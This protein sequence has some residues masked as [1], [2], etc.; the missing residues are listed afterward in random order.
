[1]F[2]RKTSIVCLGILACL[3]LIGCAGG[4]GGGAS[5]SGVTDGPAITS[6]VS[7][8]M[9]SLQSG[10]GKS[11]Q[12]Y[13]SAKMMLQVSEGSSVGN[14]T[15]WDFGTDLSNP[16]DDASFTFT[17]P[18]G[19]II[20]PSPD[21]AEVTAEYFAA[22]GTIMTAFFVLVK[23]DGAWYIDAISFTSRGTST[24]N[25]AS[26][27]PLA[28]G[29][30]REY[31]VTDLKTNEVTYE[32]TVIDSDP[33]VIDGKNFYRFSETPSTSGTT[34]TPITAR[35]TSQVDPLDGA[36]GSEYFSNEFGLYFYI[37]E[38]NFNGGKPVKYLDSTLYPGMIATGTFTRIIEEENYTIAFQ[39][40]VGAV[41]SFQT[42]VQTFTALPLTIEWKAYRTGEATVVE[43][44]KEMVRLVSG[45]GQVGLTTYDV[46]TNQEIKREVIV[47]GTVGG[48][49]YQEP[50]ATP[51]QISTTSPL[52]GATVG[53]SYSQSLSAQGGTAPYTWVQTTTSLP[54][55]LTLSAS[56]VISGTPTTA[57]SS[58]FS[59]TVTDA[60]GATDSETFSL[61][62]S[63]GSTGSTLQIT[64]T[65][66]S[67]GT[68]GVAY[69]QTLAAS[70][71]TSPYSWSLSS[72]VLPSG[73]TLAT[74]TGIISGTTTAT[75]SYSFSVTVKDSAG[76]TSTSQFTLTVQTATGGPTLTTTS[77][78]PNATL[79]QSYTLTLEV[80]GGT[81][82]YAYSQTAG[83]MPPGVRLSSNRVTGT[84][85]TA[86]TYNFT[87]QVRD[88]AGLTSAKEFQLTVSGAT[89]VS[90]VMKIEATLVAAN[91]IQVRF[92]D[93]SNVA[94]LPEQV[95][96]AAVSNYLL[97]DTRIKKTDN[98][99]V[100]VETMADSVTLSGTTADV[101]FSVAVSALPNWTFRAQNILS[102]GGTLTVATSPV[103]ILNH[104]S[105]LSFKPW[106][107]FGFTTEM[108]RPFKIRNPGEDGSTATLFF[109]A[110][111]QISSVQMEET[112]VN[113]SV[114]LGVSTAVTQW[115]APQ[116]NPVTNTFFDFLQT[117]AGSSKSLWS[118]F[119]IS[120]SSTKVALQAF[121]TGSV[122]TERETSE[123]TSGVVGG[124]HFDVFD[125]YTG[126]ATV[127]ATLL[128]ETNQLRAVD[129]GGSASLS[130]TSA[131]AVGATV[132]GMDSNHDGSATAAQIRLVDDQGH[133]KS[134]S[135]P[136]NSAT[137]APL[138]IYTIP[139][140]PV[141]NKFGLFWMKNL[142]G[143]DGQFMY[144]NAAANKVTLVDTGSGSDIWSI[145]ETSNTD[146]K[147]RLNNP[148]SVTV[149]AS[150]NYNATSRPYDYWILVSDFDGLSI[151]RRY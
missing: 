85:T 108:K 18:K 139:G 26:Y 89:S 140:T 24:I 87:I 118:F 114:Q 19:G 45:I 10:D 91:R 37:D 147:G 102:A 98:S 25:V 49:T 8:F 136:Y 35:I 63:T 47:N 127:S 86:G 30:A 113:G 92:F 57:Q 44:R 150:P 130:N 7:G 138:T 81:S 70:G 115:F 103:Q 43:A 83:T 48:K 78:L 14:L 148:R 12:K 105:F 131:T 104:V 106:S 58:T 66:L 73:Y 36:T 121:Q 31:Q 28:K 46:D 95:A 88:G 75:G 1:M 151:Y 60:K 50:A 101:E 135:F 15:I 68:P 38:P 84:P 144:T 40:T 132:T 149:F 111:E 65:T 72:G 77:P 4:G 110:P 99:D 93:Q 16:A 120:G 119:G 20:Q 67:N 143:N 109:V 34:T 129:L 117:G 61:T 54:T 96:A 59:V 62:V 141:G 125:F 11:A 52:P 80:S 142:S 55:G 32:R 29:D 71:G 13:L 137:P 97:K 124:M 17:I 42:P 100:S 27:F 9:S 33:K 21:Y 116:V 79:N 5:V 146:I 90:G 53:T 74:T 82:P 128:A 133:I 145:G 2:V 6:V 94:T 112:L 134:T 123:A 56:G 107:D 51:L 64:T 3:A 41:T 23:V 69:S 122:P 39:F 126:T 76:A 22:D